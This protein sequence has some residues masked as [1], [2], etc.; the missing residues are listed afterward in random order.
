VREN[1]GQDAKLVNLKHIG[2]S[3][4]WWHTPL[5]SALGNRGR[6]IFLESSRTSGAMETNPVSKEKERV[7]SLGVFHLLSIIHGQ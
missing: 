3:W 7:S 5:I 1:C 2:L 4:L 6:Q